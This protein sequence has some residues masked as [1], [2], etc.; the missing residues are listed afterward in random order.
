MSRRWICFYM[1]GVA[2]TVLLSSTN[3]VTVQWLITSI[4]GRMGHFLFY[5]ST[6]P[7]D[8]PFFIL[9]KYIAYRWSISL[10][11]E[12]MFKNY[13]WIFQSTQR[14]TDIQSSRPAV[15]TGTSLVVNNKLKTNLQL[16]LTTITTLFLIISTFTWKITTNPHE[17]L[18]LHNYIVRT[19]IKTA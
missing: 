3:W 4:T 8:G 10:H 11:Y 15:L 6:S 5:T 9:Y 13:I 16:C 17:D 2:S 18:T 14:P 19:F 12:K 7:I 1:S